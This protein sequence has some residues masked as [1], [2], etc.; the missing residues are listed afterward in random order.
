MNPKPDDSYHLPE[1]D[2]SKPPGDAGGSAVEAEQTFL[3]VP[4]VEKLSTENARLEG[5][6]A[7]A[8]PE[9]PWY[10]SILIV[11]L[12]GVLAGFLFLIR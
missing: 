11:A 8:L 7:K 9:N 4:A 12:V 6:A 2:L 5:N 1:G 10:L 3:D